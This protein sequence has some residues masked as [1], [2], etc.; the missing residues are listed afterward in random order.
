MRQGKFRMPDND[1]S[2]NCSGPTGRRQHSWLGGWVQVL[3]QDPNSGRHYQARWNHS[4]DWS[5][6]RRADRMSVILIPKGSIPRGMS[7]NS[8][9]AVWQP[10]AIFNQQHS[11]TCAR[12]QIRHMQRSLPWRFASES[13]AT[14]NSPVLQVDTD[15]LL[16]WSKSIDSSKR[17]TYPSSLDVIDRR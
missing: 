5:T 14:R 4:G 13:S 11:I 16:A 1:A 2:E 17:A 15:A 12:L 9:V 8:H 6:T 3:L 10:L 7:L